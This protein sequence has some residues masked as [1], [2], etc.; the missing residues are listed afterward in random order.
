[1]IDLEH[2]ISPHNILQEQQVGRPWGVWRILVCCQLL[3]RTHGRQVRPMIEDFFERWPDPMS[4][5]NSEPEPLRR[6]LKPLGFGEQRYRQLTTM[7]KQYLELTRADRLFWKG[8]VDGAWC[9]SLVGCGRYA[10]ESLDLVV[11]GV[12]DAP[13]TDHWLLRYQQWRIGRRAL[14]ERGLA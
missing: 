10:K 6:A 12:L 5:A 11:Y 14:K 1:M 7:S 9:T 2:T 3:N 8:Y 4:V 13:T